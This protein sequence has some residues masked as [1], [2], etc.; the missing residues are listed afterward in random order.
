MGAWY[1]A[2][3]SITKRINKMKLIQ[4]DYGEGFYGKCFWVRIF[5]HG[6]H[7]KKYDS[8]ILF[9]ERYRLSPSV[10]IFGFRF[11]YLLPRNNHEH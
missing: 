9:S 1:L 6:L 7:V 4:W 10:V 11:K 3:V 2:L 8:L 5:G